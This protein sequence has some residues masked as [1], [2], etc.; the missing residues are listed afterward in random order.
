M[1]FFFFFSIQLHFF[2]FTHFLSKGL[3]HFTYLVTEFVCDLE[4]MRRWFPWASP[5]SASW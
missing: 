3:I 4:E 5:Y 1:I 2:C